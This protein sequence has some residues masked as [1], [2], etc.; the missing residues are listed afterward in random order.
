M[1]N[2]TISYDEN[3]YFSSIFHKF[4]PILSILIKL[5]PRTTKK[6]KKKILFTNF[7][8]NSTSRYKGYRSSEIVSKIHPV[9]VSRRKWRLLLENYPLSIELRFSYSNQDNHYRKNHVRV[10]LSR[11]SSSLSHPLFR[12]REFVCRVKGTPCGDRPR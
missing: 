6:K 12:P 4:F 8:P 7:L 9:I 5:F 1:R 11:P 10:F 2:T 3:K